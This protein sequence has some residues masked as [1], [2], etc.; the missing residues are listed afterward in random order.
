MIKPY[1][2]LQYGENVAGHNVPV[3][4]EREIRAA[5]GILFVCLAF[6]L[7]LILFRQDFL[8]VKYVLVGFLTDFIIRVLIHPKFSPTLIMGRLIVRRQPAEYVG[9][10]QKRF[11]WSIGLF[12]SSLMFVLLVVFNSY[13]LITSVT[14]FICLTFLFMETAF[15]I[16]AGCFVYRLFYKN[17][18]TACI[19]D[20]CA[21]KRKGTAQPTSWAQLASLFSFL[22][23]VLLTI[24]LFQDDFRKPPKK[25]GEDRK[26]VVKH[27]VSFSAE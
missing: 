11:A 20:Q 12:L 8:L 21:P 14:C 25:L 16:C 17:K 13:S 3:L 24:V 9:A 23:V 27:T 19:G 22:L 4:N 5:A 26:T 18:A 7:M 15:G 1:P 2:F 6:S 10:A